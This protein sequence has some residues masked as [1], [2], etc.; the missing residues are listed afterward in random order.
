M[1]SGPSLG[2]RIAGLVV[3]TLLVT[4][5]LATLIFPFVAGFL[6]LGMA[7]GVTGFASLTAWIGFAFGAKGQPAHWFAFWSH[8]NFYLAG[9]YVAAP[10]YI[11][12]GT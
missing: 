6:K 5:G 3:V 12:V 8:L 4:A 2:L 1:T 9:A 10:A 7:P 11:G